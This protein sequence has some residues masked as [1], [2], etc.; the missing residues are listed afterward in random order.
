MVRTIALAFAAFWFVFTLA[1]AT[2]FVVALACGGQGF[3]DFF[4]EATMAFA[5]L[6]IAAVVIAMGAPE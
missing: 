6:L 2:G 5:C 3:R 1:C 4:R